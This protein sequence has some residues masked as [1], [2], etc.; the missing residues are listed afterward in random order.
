MGVN[1][2]PETWSR[3]ERL[4]IGVVCL[5]T[6]VGA[7]GLAVWQQLSEARLRFEEQTGSQ[8]RTVTH[9]IEGALAILE[10]LSTYHQVHGSMETPGF[11]DMVT[12][13]LAQQ[14]RLATLAYLNTVPA[15]NEREFALESMNRSDATG[16]SRT[17][18][19]GIPPAFPDT[20]RPEAGP[21][22]SPRLLR[23]A[24]LAARTA[25]TQIV[26]S[27]IV[28]GDPGRLDLIRATYTGD[29]VPD[30]EQ[31]RLR[32]FNGLLLVSVDLPS[33]LP[34]PS[35]PA[36]YLSVNIMRAGER[37]QEESP[38]MLAD[39][40]FSRF[41]LPRLS[42]SKSI[43]VGDAEVRVT[44]LATPSWTRLDPVHIGSVVIAAGILLAGTLRLLR[45]HKA[46]HRRVQIAERSVSAEKERAEITLRS[47]GDAVVTTDTHC[48]IRYMNPAAEQLTGWRLEM[49]QYRSISDIVLLYDE[50]N[51]ERIETGNTIC[52][53][54][55]PPR[56]LDSRGICL[57]RG[58]GELVSVHCGSSP[59]SDNQGR[60]LGR[61]LV[62]HDVSIERELSHALDFQSR[63]DGLTGLVNRHEFE[64]V[65]ERALD[66]IPEGTSGHVL[67]YLDV[68]QFRLINDTSGHTAGD[69]LIRELTGLLRRQL[70]REDVVAR[71]GGDE[72]GVLLRQT[73]VELAAKVA[74]RLRQE[75]NAFRF[76]Y[77]QNRFQVS[78]SI[79]VVPIDHS[80]AN[81][82]DLLSG[83]DLAC[84]A[85]KDAGRNRIHVYDR[86]DRRMRERHGQMQWLPRL[87]QALE[88]DQFVLHDQQ[89]ESLGP[90]VHPHRMRE[91]LIRLK[92]DQGDLTPP[93]AFIPAAERYG[94][95][96][97][98]D[99]WVITHAFQ[100][101]GRLVRTHAAELEDTV[102]TINLSGQ[103]MG[104]GSTSRFIQEQVDRH[105]VDPARFCFEITETAAITNF[106][107]ARHLIQTLKEIGFR[108]A[109]DDFG[110]GLSSFGYLKR[111]PVDF[112]KI[113]GQFVRDMVRDPVD[114]AVV[115][116][117]R[118]FT[119]VLGIRTIAEYV[120]DR[121]TLELL[122]DLGVDYAQGYF[123][124]AP[125]P[126]CDPQ[127]AQGDELDAGAAY[128]RTG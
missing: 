4:L 123:L 121:E 80:R 84:Y 33:A 94:M 30:D 16:G 91:L 116:S 126:F 36:T 5:V 57:Y 63:H 68:D 97:Q 62:I 21:A 3:R 77:G 39:N 83:A 60:T 35:G 45:Y 101:V 43:E 49:A 79:G 110:S 29:A 34:D 58:S 26:A 107:Q 6:L 112:L 66:G 118:E 122:R 95:M 73:S 92:S 100:T 124:G 27:P 64:R 24:D 8:V 81:V 28:S 20:G 59:I 74:E 17:H 69:A 111:L 2:T 44:A 89:I 15:P 117:I 87:Q 14:P 40:E 86:D 42:V 67:L 106:S 113:D 25:I 1:R 85:A 31:A 51:G 12:A 41:S 10:V 53:L 114:R 22:Q 96:A 61:V 78:V 108:F 56:A 98:L 76:T 115:K 38:D 82:T 70:R 103:S 19:N 54:D 119:T 37:N 11:A 128:A 127:L 71:L 32:R 23:A 48:R 50:E 120:E 47:I 55:S 18:P 9:Q 13:L 104:S 46:V 52:R 65:L 99:R 102:F 75:I 7:S 93:G 72:F 125:T 109:L 90:G 88:H 105:D